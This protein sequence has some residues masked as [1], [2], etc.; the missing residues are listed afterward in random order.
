[1]GREGAESRERSDRLRWRAEESDRHNTALHPGPAPWPEVDPASEHGGEGDGA[2]P[3]SQVTNKCTKV[4][5]GELTDRSCSKICLVKVFPAGH[6]EKAVK[7]YAIIDE[8]SNRSLVRPQFFDMFNDHSPSAPAGVY[9]ENM[10][11]SEAIS[12]QKGQWL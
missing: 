1:M 8:Q 3:Q 11:W 10:C 4:C 6:R 7:L 2:S 9:T 5:G 12:R